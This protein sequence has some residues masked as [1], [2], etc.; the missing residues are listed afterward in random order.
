MAKQ[1]RYTL[2]RRLANRLMKRLVKLGFGTPKT[3]LLSV[4][5]RRTGR[6]Y[7]TPVNLVERDGMRYVVSPY[8][9]RSWVRNA[10]AS[11]EVS[12]RRG[13]RNETLGVEEIPASEAVPVLR[14]YWQQNAITRSFFEVGPD[15]AH[16]AFLVE[17]QRHPVFRLTER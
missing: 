5:G 4:M 12:L 2:I 1:Y 15:A 7:E 16:D 13:R 11:G 9:E 8:G 17:A 10:R 6:T 14:D 3:H